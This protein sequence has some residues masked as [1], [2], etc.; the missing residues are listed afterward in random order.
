MYC[1]LVAGIISSASLASRCRVSICCH[2]IPCTPDAYLATSVK[3]MAHVFDLGNNFQNFLRRYFFDSIVLY[4]SLFNYNIKIRNF[5][6]HNFIFFQIFM[7]TDIVIALVFVNNSEKKC[8]CKSIIAYR[9]QFV[10]RRINE[11]LIDS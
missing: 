8:W 3:R 10:K 6:S 4:I 11:V 7:V 5:F 2:N 1:V 9:N